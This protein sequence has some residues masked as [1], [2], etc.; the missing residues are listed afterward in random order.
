VEDLYF[1]VHFAVVDFVHLVLVV[2]M[3]AF[4]LLVYQFFVVEVVVVETLA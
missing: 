4:A 1:V 3:K 2:G